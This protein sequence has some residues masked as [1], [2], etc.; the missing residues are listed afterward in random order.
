MK[1]FYFH[2]K[3]FIRLLLFFVFIYQT[4]SNIYAQ[5]TLDGEFRNKSM[6]M[7]GY[8][9][10]LNSAKHP[11][12]IIIQ[13]SRLNLNYKNENISYCLSFQ[14]VRSW[15]QDDYGVSNPSINL[16]EAWVNF[17]FNDYWNIKFG[18]QKIQYDDGRL[19]SY[20]NWRD[21]A[22]VHDLAIFKYK[23]SS[24]LFTADLGLAMNN[25][26]SYQNYLTEY[27]LKNYKYLGYLWLNKSFF[28]SKLN[29][30]LMNIADI[31]QKPKNTNS[32]NTRFTT[33]PYVS[34]KN[35]NIN[36]KGSYYYQGGK[37]ADGKKVNSFFYGI[38]LGYNLNKS[39]EISIGYDHYSGTD[40]KD[41]VKAKSESSTFDKLYGTA[42]TFLGYMDYFS[43]NTSD[44]TKGAGINDLFARLNY[45]MNDK[46][47][48]EL[49]YHIFSLDKQYIPYTGKE[50]VRL[51]KD[52]GQ[53]IDFVY[54]YKYNKNVNFQLGYF[55]MLP[56]ETLEKLHDYNKG[57]SK[58][59]QFIYLMATFKPTFFSSK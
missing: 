53:E 29:F 23:N 31:N 9:E 7:D 57:D 8:K 21:N 36:F 12:G 27:T 45:K 48:I 39:A 25:P 43:G 10:L 59:A 38:S 42:H 49:V 32:F 51:D 13:R 40:F 18:R 16:F 20:V 54:T 47:D 28:D 3:L 26:A 17:G 33:G 11:Y 46:H 24:K 44:K 35:E 58:F 55:V 30:S 50:S 2:K 37:L 22:V 56:S 1:A 5:L 19:L 34:F 15:G 4:G 41:T 14:D 52:L 6:Y